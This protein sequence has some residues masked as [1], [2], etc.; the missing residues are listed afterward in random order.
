MQ[1]G[2]AVLNAAE[3][4]RLSRLRI[5]LAE[6]QSRIADQSALASTSRSSALTA[7]ASSRSAS[8]HTSVVSIEPSSRCQPRFR[9]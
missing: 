8:A 1:E 6:A 2:T 7:L 3:T 4:E 9:V 5:M